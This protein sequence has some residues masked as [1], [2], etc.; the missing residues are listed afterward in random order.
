MRLL[1]YASG[2]VAARPR[3]LGDGR[4]GLG[5]GGCRSLVSVTVTSSATAVSP[6]GRASGRR[7]RAGLGPLPQVARRGRTRNLAT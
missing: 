6:P 1:G 4:L 5:P 3:R 2:L 7:H